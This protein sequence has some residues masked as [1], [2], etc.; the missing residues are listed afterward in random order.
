MSEAFIGEVRVFGGNFAP[1]N[2]HL[3][4]GSL[5]PISQYE[6]L[7]AL[8]GTV[9]GGNGVNTFGIPDLRGRLPVGQGQGLGLTN[10]IIGQS[11]GSESVSLV[12]NQLPAHNHA[13]NAT[14]DTAVAPS[15]ANGVFAT[16]TDG[17]KIYV[18]ANGT[19]QPAVLAANSVVQT[20]GSQPHDNIMPSLGISYIIC[21]NGIFPSR[22]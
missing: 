10:R 5:L 1:V 3:C 6:A 17:D 11:F 14:T 18:A 21:L 9:Y 19:N 8:I 12:T 4:D 15:P 20:G 2:W 22:N 13:F 7:F 16:Q